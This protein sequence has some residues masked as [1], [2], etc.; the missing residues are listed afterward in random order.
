MVVQMVANMSDYTCD[1]WV[2]I[3]MKGD[4]PHYRLLVGT[5]GGYLDGDSWRMNSGITK[6]EE[7]EECYYFY[8]SSGSRY[9]CYKESYTLRMNNAHIWTQLQGMHDDKVE[10]MPE[11]TDWMNM[12]WIISYHEVS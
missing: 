10:M 1:N 6:V 12:D 2:V 4:D 5:S 11:D 9:R 8:G 7:D 3:K